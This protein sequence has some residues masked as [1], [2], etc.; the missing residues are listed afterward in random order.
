MNE[1]NQLIKKEKKMKFAIPTAQGKLCQH[2]G[3]CEK[4]VFIEVDENKKEITNKEEITPPEHV[5]GIIPPW[6]AEQGATI[7]LAGGMGARAI[8]LFDEQGI[9]VV[10]GCQADIPEKLVNDYLNDKLVAGT[11]ACDH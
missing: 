2:F 11:N 8:G 6:V 3:H 10:V 5:P 9:K 1:S 4:F 7:V